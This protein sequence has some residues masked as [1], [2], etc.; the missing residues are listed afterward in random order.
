MTYFVLRFVWVLLFVGLVGCSPTPVGIDSAS[1]TPAQQVIIRA[2]QPT[3][4]ATIWLTATH[5]PLPLVSAIP[6]ERPVA[7]A[8]VTYQLQAGMTVTP[9]PPQTETAVLPDLA[10]SRG[11]VLSGITDQ[12]REIFR[13][14]RQL[15]NRANVFSKIGDSL[16]V[17][18]YVLYP[19][20]WGASN[21]HQYQGLRP[22]IEYFSTA[23]ARDGNSFANISLS[24]DNGWTTQS[25]FDP[26]RAN[27]EICVP[28]QAPLLC[29]YRIVRPGIA[30]ILLGTNDVAELPAATYRAN[31][32]RIVE[33]SIN[34]GI[35]PVLSTLPEREGYEHQVAAF[36][37]IIWELAQEFGVP[38][39]DYGLAMSNLP[40]GGLSQDGVHPSWPPGDFHAAVDF[41]PANLRYG[42]TMRN[43]TALLALDALWR[44]VITTD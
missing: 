37:A 4:I 26:A 34:R 43:L 11:A 28:G 1:A 41:S 7:R 5:T 14:G 17:A 40:N 38:V 21:L 25:V 31:M 39:W 2:A 33:V 24:A 30:L 18:T 20:G 8:T 13:L 35:V 15:G 27:R 6:T 10:L 19:I 16:T 9:S 12:T 22:V 36:N 44:Q 32:Q 23:N 42:Y 29:E 3:K